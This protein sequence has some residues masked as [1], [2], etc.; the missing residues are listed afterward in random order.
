MRRR[1]FIVLLGG[2]ATW[3]LAVRAQQPVTPVIG[4]LSS[5]SADVFVNDLAGF[6]G[7]LSEVGY[8]ERRNV[9]IEYRWAG[10]Q[11]DRLPALAADLARRAVTVI[12]ASGGAV[13]ALAAKAATSTIPIVFVM[14]DDPVRFG[15][16]ASLSRPNSNVTGVTLFISE[17]MAKRLELLISAMPGTPAIAMLVNPKNPNAES[18]A[19]EIEAAARTSGRALRLLNASTEGDIEVAFESLVQ[20]RLSALLVGTDTFFYGRRD[21]LVALAASHTIP[22]IYFER[23]FVTAGGLM[24]YG[25]NFSG[26]WRQAG[27]YVSR[28]LKGEKPGDL[29]VLQP[30][31]FEFVI[32]RKTAKALGVDI[33]PSLLATADEVIE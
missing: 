12:V 25:P 9:A 28:I 2:A 19:K 14:G 29:P 20:Q 13:S 33:P 6:R 4:F 8:V 3:P 11:Y 10:G 26:E 22:A 24:S 21:Q 32:N 31:K 1:D 16:V 18:E 17:L 7:G 23:E 27:I 30:T 5:G 15:I